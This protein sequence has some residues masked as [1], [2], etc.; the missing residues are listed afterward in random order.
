MHWASS[1]RIRSDRQAHQDLCR[2]TR[3]I[4]ISSKGLMTSMQRHPLLLRRVILWQR[5]EQQQRRRRQSGRAGTRLRVRQRQRQSRPLPS[6]RSGQHSSRL[7][8]G[9]VGTTT[10]HR[11]RRERS[12]PPRRRHRRLSEIR[13]LRL[14]V[15]DVPRLAPRWLPQQQAARPSFLRKLHPSAPCI[16]EVKMRTCK[17]WLVP[18]C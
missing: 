18:K 1:P 3:S 12:S 9:M 10:R 4:S 2:S 16:C 13:H 17:H 15:G 11:Q 5:Q 8:T 14:R 6:A 7:T